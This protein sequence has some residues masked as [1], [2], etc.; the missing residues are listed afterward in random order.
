MADAR[1][2]AE[3]MAKLSG[4]K[5]GAPI[6]ISESLGLPVSVP[7]RINVPGQTPISP[8]E[9]AVTSTVQVVYTIR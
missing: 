6:F 7:V 9:V 3:Q 5:L 2:K 8:G 4:V 1:A